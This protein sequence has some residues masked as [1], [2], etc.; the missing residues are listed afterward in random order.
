MLLNPQGHQLISHRSQEFINN[1]ERFVWYVS[2]VNGVIGAYFFENVTERT[3]TTNG[4]RYRRMKSVITTVD[5]QLGNN[6]ILNFIKTTR[7]CQQSCGSN[8]SA[9]L[10]LY[11][12]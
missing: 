10:F 11:I 6:V 4:L 5:P 12:T 3:V 1:Y 9:I 2:W 7:V 8:L